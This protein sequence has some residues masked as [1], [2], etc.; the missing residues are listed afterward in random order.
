VADG[1]PDIAADNVWDVMDDVTQTRD[2][3]TFDNLVL[4]ERPECGWQDI[5]ETE[6]LGPE[7]V[8]HDSR[9]RAEVHPNAGKN[10]FE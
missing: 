2:D 3:L 5:P 7:A 10:F 8:V 9:P 4:G 6:L 1:T